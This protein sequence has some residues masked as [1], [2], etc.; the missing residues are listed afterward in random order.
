MG[1]YKISEC[2]ANRTF[3]FFLFI[4]LLLL[5]RTCTTFGNGA[6]VVVVGGDDMADE[7]T[8]LLLLWFIVIFR[9]LSLRIRLGNRGGG[10]FV[11]TD[12][13]DGVVE[14]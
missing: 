13:D 8:L 9:T 2:G 11:D 10:G 12:V 14:L 4:I 6:G 7:T 3:R 1:I 5:F